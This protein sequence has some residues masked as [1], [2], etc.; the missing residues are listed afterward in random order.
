L[1]VFPI[2]IIAVLRIVAYPLLS[3]WG[4]VISTNVI[5]VDENLPRFFEAVKLQDADWFVNEANYLKDQYQFTFANKKVVDTLDEWAVAK[6]PI[7]GIAWYN[8]LANPYYSRDFSYIS[9]DTPNR[10][11]LVIDGDDDEDN[12][13]EQSDMVS[14]L[15]NLAYVRQTVAKSFEFN[16]NYRKDFGA[17]MTQAKIEH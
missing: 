7:S 4:F 3:S 6:K 17:A 12:D 2:F 8:V 10:N 16:P 13:C 14:I 5:S 9:V 11:D 1:L 15:I